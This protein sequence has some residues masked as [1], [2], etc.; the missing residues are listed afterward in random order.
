[1]AI[2]VYGLCAATALMCAFL[3]LRAFRATRSSVLWWS[4][5]CFSGLVLSNLILVVDKLVFPQVDLLGLRL[6][7]TLVSLGLLLHGLINSSE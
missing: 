3:L 7:I 1:M 4:G 2:F 5:L 6:W